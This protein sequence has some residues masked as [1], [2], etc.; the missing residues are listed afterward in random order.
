MNKYIVKIYMD[1]R[2]YII[3]RSTSAAD[4]MDSIFERSLRSSKKEN[5]NYKHTKV[6]IILTGH[7]LI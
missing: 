3:F 7:F 4:F 1:K 5:E 6:Q 2:F